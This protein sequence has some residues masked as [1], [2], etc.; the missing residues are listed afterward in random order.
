MYVNAKGNRKQQE[1]M[2]GTAMHAQGTGL[3]ACAFL[4]FS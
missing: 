1:Q 3:Q 4:S 2:D